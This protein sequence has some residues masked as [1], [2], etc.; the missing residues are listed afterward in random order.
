MIFTSNYK[1]NN[2]PNRASQR[3][4]KDRLSIDVYRGFIEKFC[5]FWDRREALLPTNK[6]LI[7][8][9]IP[10]P[11]KAKKKTALPQ[12]SMK[13]EPITQELLRE[14]SEGSGS[15]IVLCLLY[16]DRDKS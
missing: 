3:S 7:T 13:A 1:S 15:G 16:S 11:N 10:P 6:H 5:L 14:C 2:H 4:E 8:S 9:P 12:P